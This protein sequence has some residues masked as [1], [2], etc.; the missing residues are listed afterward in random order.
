MRLPDDESW[1]HAYLMV[2]YDAEVDWPAVADRIK[3]SLERRWNWNRV[4]KAFLSDKAQCA[5]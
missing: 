3:R 1:L 4:G 2:P 5:Q